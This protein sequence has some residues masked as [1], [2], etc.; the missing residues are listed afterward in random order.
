MSKQQDFLTILKGNRMEDIT[1]EGRD[2][3]MINRV[4]LSRATVNEVDK[5]SELLNE[6]RAIGYSKI[7]VDLSQ[8]TNLD[9]TF[10]GVLVLTHK[11][12]LAKGG[13]LTLVEPLD[14]ARELFQLTGIS[15]VISTFETAEDAIMSFNIN[16]EIKEIAFAQ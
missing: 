7:V 12:L 9:S 16:P 8:C 13:N 5:L 6:Q 15:K 14:P 1:Q 10:I 11:Q 4:N 2:N 3:V